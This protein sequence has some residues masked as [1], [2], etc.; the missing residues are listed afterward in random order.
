METEIKFG[1]PEENQMPPEPVQLRADELKDHVDNR[2]KRRKSKQGFSELKQPE[3][4]KE[5]TEVEVVAKATPE[6]A[7]AEAIKPRIDRQP[8]V[9]EG[10]IARRTPRG[11]ARPL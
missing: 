8:V 11:A 9:K 10:K 7:K 6:Q 2:A 4:Q 5:E 3:K 1:A